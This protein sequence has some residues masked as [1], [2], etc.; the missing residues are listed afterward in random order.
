MEHVMTVRNDL[1]VI[2]QGQDQRLKALEVYEEGMM[3]EEVMR[4]MASCIEDAKEEARQLYQV[5]S[6]ISPSKDCE[7]R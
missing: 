1:M 6:P 4:W 3:K 7:R 2:L 5:R